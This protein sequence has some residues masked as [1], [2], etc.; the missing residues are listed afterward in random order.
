[1]GHGTHRHDALPVLTPCPPLHKCGEGELRAALSFPL[2]AYA[3]RGTGGEDHGE[4]I[5]G[6]RI[7]GLRYVSR[8]SRRENAPAATTRVSS[9]RTAGAVRRHASSQGVC[10]TSR[11]NASAGERGV[12][13]V[14]SA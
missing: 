6:V 5:K 2:S 4:G 10:R 9:A 7:A 13:R 1:A 14:G 8:P 11:A 12:S 3:E